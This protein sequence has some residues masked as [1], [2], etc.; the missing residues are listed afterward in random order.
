M[1]HRNP[2]G[3]PSEVHLYNQYDIA[4]NLWKAVDGRGI[5]TDFDF[6]DRFGSLADDARANAGAP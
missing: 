4:G 5:P 6:S 3:S 2:G 1:I